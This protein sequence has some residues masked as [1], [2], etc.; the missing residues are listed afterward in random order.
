[1]KD[2]NSLHDVQPVAMM[3]RVG[4]DTEC[5][6]ATSQDSSVLSWDTRRQATQSRTGNRLRKGAVW[7]EA[8]NCPPQAMAHALRLPFTL[9][10][11]N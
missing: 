3:Q 9:Q 8:K 6:S 11:C 4:V 10:P 5:T 1:M 7:G 2:I